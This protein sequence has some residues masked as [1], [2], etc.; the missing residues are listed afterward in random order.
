MRIVRVVRWLGVAAG[1]AI[2]APAVSSAQVSLS[3]T[4]GPPALP[5]YE[6]PPCPQPDYIW[7]P[8]YWQY[9]S[10]VGYY[11]VPGTWV[12]APTPGYLWTPGYWG[13]NNG[14]YVG[15]NGHWGQDVR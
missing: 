8:G 10:N 12:P 15:S 9:A 13:W 7:T 14:L 3:I 5:M 6:Q 2:A 4:I 11:W 1:V